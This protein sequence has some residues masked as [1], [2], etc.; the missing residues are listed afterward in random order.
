MTWKENLAFVDLQLWAGSDSQ[1]VCKS[2]C[3][4]I[5]LMAH[6][7]VESQMYFQISVRTCGLQHFHK[8]FCVINVPMQN[9]KEEM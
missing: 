3:N 6:L 1:F 8:W 5:D 7:Q 9:R 2:A 4:F